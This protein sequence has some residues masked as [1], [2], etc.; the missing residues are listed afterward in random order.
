MSTTDN[1]QIL[2]RWSVAELI[3]A[4]TWPRVIA[5]VLLPP[6]GAQPAGAQPAGAQG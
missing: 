1:P 6:T 5:A 4:A 3:A 2:R